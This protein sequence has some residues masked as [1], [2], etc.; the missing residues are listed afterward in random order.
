MKAAKISIIVL[1]SL[2]TLLAASLFLAPL[3]L[4]SGTITDLDA[5]ANRIDHE[6][7]WEDLPPYQKAV[8]Y[9][10]DI[11]CH[12]K[13][14]RSFYINGNQMPVCSR[15]V[16][17]FIGNAIGIIP[18]LFIPISSYVLE[19]M[20]GVFPKKIKEKALKKPIMKWGLVL[21]LAFLSVVPLIIDGSYQLISQTSASIADYESNNALRMLT[22]LMFGAFGGYWIGSMVAAL[23]YIT[24]EEN[25]KQKEAPENIT[26]DNEENG[27]IK[28]E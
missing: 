27:D 7:L 24:T 26:N 1:L 6:D 11:N 28:E 14:S 25:S 12:Q 22:G 3:T 18:L 4:E 19:T 8:Y 15:D 20:L 23:F 9:F 21:G 16:G 17:V 2:S 13:S 5:N 10:G